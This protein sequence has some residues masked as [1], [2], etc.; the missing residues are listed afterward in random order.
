MSS[1]EEVASALGRPWRAPRD[2]S[3]PTF[4]AGQ[5]AWLVDRGG[6]RVIDATSGALNVFCGHGVE[7]IVDAHLSQLRTLA[8]VDMAQGLT[9]PAH[10]LADGL[11]DIRGHGGDRF[12]FANSG[13]EAIELAVGLSSR[14]WAAVD[15][16]M[17]GHRRLRARLPRLDRAVP[18]A[19]RP[20]A[21]QQRTGRVRG[22]RPSSDVRRVHRRRAAVGS[23]A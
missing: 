20:A 2:H 8:H 6:H 23:G 19:V 3:G 11:R 4:V 9:E 7:P 22:A 1:G 12:F 15:S 21:D 13:S 17:D 10:R 18:V 5:G 16:R 14:Y